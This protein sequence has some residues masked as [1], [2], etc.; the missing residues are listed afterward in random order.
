VATFAELY[1]FV[2]VSRVEDT[3]DIL[4]VLKQLAENAAENAAASVYKRL[5]YTQ[6]PLQTERE[7]GK[8]LLDSSQLCGPLLT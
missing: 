8:A 7:A 1:L 2:A 5:K 4:G 3:P 6:S